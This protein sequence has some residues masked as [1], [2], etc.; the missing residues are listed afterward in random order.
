[1]TLSQVHDPRAGDAWRFDAGM[2]IEHF[3]GV[4]WVAWVT[5][6]T[7]LVPFVGRDTTFHLDP[8][9]IRQAHFQL[10]STLSAIQDRW[11]DAYLLDVFLPVRQGRDSTAILLG[12]VRIDSLWLKRHSMVGGNLSITLANDNENRL[13]LNALPDS[14][15]PRWMR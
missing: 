3:P 8:E 6:D 5:P 10:H 2:V 14:L 7:A 4:Q 12:E 13:V 15:A 11:T 1:V 9:L